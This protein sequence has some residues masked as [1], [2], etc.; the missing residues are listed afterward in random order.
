MEIT[1]Y[2][3]KEKNKSQINYLVC[4]NFSYKGTVKCIATYK[5]ATMGSFEDSRRVSPTPK[6]SL[7]TPQTQSMW[8][9]GADK[10]QQAKNKRS[11]TNNKQ[12]T[13]PKY[14]KR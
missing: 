4:T 11:Y 2:M 10:K 9:V 13:A 8:R 1:C 12:R 3:K 6:S 5:K 14:I 7:E